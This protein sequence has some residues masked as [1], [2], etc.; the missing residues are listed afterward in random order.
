MSKRDTPGAVHIGRSQIMTVTNVAKQV[1]EFLTLREAAKVLRLH[2]R[3][4]RE[5]IRRG[6]L[7]ARIIG[8]RY[9]FRRSDLDT[10]FENAPTNWDFS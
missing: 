10:F 1:D 9:R 7:K 6:E 5:Y 8:R 2:P 4:V 3:T